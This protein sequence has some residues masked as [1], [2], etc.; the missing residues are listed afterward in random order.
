MHG[1]RFALETEMKNEPE[2]DDGLCELAR[3][4]LFDSV[5]FEAS[6]DP[7]VRGLDLDMQTF[8]AATRT[9]SG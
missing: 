7:S 3:L 9:T 6:A 8:S 2:L 1:L 5:Y 4:G